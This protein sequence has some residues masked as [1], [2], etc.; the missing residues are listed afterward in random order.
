MDDY[1]GVFE[2][3]LYVHFF[4]IL[5]MYLVF[6][7]YMKINYQIHE[8][9]RDMKYDILLKVSMSEYSDNQ[10]NTSEKDRF[11]TKFI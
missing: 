2:T 9:N 4:S 11:E 6:N 1:E 3:F 7:A 8:T 5:V 10:K